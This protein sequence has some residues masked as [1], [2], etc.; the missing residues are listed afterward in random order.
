M[1]S[2]AEV[3]REQKISA[4]TL[5]KVYEMKKLVDESVRATMTDATVPRDQ[6]VAAM[7]SI[8]EQTQ[9]AIV[10][11]LGKR[12][13]KP[14]ARSYADTAAGGCRASRARVSPSKEMLA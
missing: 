7:K 11:L 1:A 9:Q 5:N 2:L 12:A 10:Q 4:D 3:G 6:R 8:G 14:T 13:G